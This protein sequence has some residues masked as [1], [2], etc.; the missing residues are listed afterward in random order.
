MVPMRRK[1]PNRKANNKMRGNRQAR[2]RPIILQR[3]KGFE[4]N[5]M[6]IPEVY[7][8]AGISGCVEVVRSA[9]PELKRKIDEEVAKGA[10]LDGCNWRAVFIEKA[11]A[12]IRKAGAKEAQVN[13]FRQKAWQSIS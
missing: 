13:E 6:L 1:E 5:L 12:E 9:I 10:S 11:A 3:I 8:K 7:R 4:A 2:P